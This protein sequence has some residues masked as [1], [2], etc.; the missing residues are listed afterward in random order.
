MVQLNLTQR[1]WLSFILLI[2]VT[3]FILALIYPLSIEGTLTEETYHII[4]DQQEQLIGINSGENLLPETGLNFVERRNAARSVGHLTV[5]AN[6]LIRKDGDP[7][8]ENILDEMGRNAFSQ[9]RELKRYELTY[10]EA[11]IFYVIRKL[12]FQ[13]QPIY[14]ISYMWDT[15]RDE[16]VQRLWV[17]LLWMLLLTTLLSMFAAVWL[18]R[19]LKEPLRILGNHLEQISNRNWKEPFHWKGDDEF[20]TLSNQFEKMR[21]NLIQSDRSQKM[22]IQHASHELKTPVMTIKSY[23]QSVKDGIMP[24]KTIEQTMDVILNQSERM[25]KRIKD[26]LY[27]TKLDS[28]KDESPNKESIHFGRLTEEVVDRFRF[29]RED[30][31]FKLDGQDKVFYGDREQWETVLENLVQNAI[32]YAVSR[33]ELN[34]YYNEESFIVKLYNDGETIPEDDISMIFD[35]FRKGNKGQFGLG[36]AIVRRIIELHDGTIKAVNE[37]SGI[38]FVIQIPRDRIEGA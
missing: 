37:S 11:T 16:L 17:R 15:Y 20:Q 21:Q 12:Q 24:K 8:P 6:Q 10:K 30:I 34:A 4:E 38:S 1:I 31:S 29:M 19:Y 33:I 26:M 23:A 14:L 35:P 32:R 28:I 18:T 27:Y 22:F 13:D 9:E 5:F 3:G 36:L 2:F 25:E 7:V